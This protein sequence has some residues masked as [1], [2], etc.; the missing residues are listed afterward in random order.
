MDKI[1]GLWSLEVAV[2]AFYIYEDEP[3]AHLTGVYDRIWVAH[4]PLG[5]V[6][7]ARLGFG[8]PRNSGDVRARLGVR[9][10]WPVLGCPYLVIRCWALIRGVSLGSLFLTRCCEISMSFDF[11]WLADLNVQDLTGD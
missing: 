1:Y 3:S 6:G 7:L 10:G 5:V 8:L 4:W 2:V 9:L 11:R